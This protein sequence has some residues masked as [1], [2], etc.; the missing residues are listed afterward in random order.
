MFLWFIKSDYVSVGFIFFLFLRLTFFLILKM[1]P[2]DTEPLDGPDKAKPPTAKKLLK[3]AAIAYSERADT[4][5]SA[6][7]RL[8]SDMSLLPAA[9]EK[10]LVD[11]IS[12]IHRNA[13]TIQSQLKN[14]ETDLNALNKQSKKWK[15]LVGSATTTSSLF[16]MKGKSE[17]GSGKTKMAKEVDQLQARAEVVDRQLRILEEMMR[18]VEEN[19]Y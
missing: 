1:N 18:I 13:A 19:E 14:L 16:F 8:S 17:N 12:E 3:Q 5:R 4:A 11:K 7:N 6:H 10:P 9:L 15:A 2:I